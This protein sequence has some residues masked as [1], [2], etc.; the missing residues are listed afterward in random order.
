MGKPDGTCS[1][2]SRFVS[3]SELLDEN[4]ADTCYD[5]TI[6]KICPALQK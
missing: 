6:I 1:G 3:V 4:A 5:A 2:T